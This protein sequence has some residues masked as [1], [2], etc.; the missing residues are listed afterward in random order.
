[1]DNDGNALVTGA[2]YYRTTV[3]IGMKVWDGAQWL[4][5]SAAQQ[6]SLVTYEYVATAGQTTFSGADANGVT[7]SYTVGNALVSVNGVRLRPGD[8][9]TATNGTSVVLVAAA[10]A[11]DEVLIDAFRTFEV[12]NTYT[13]AQVNALL[14][15]KLDTTG[16]TINGTLQVNGSNGP[17]RVGGSGYVVNP[18]NLVLGQYTS[19][20]TY[21]QFPPGGQ[22]EIW[23]GSTAEVATF[24]ENGN[25]KINGN[26]GI[27][28][29]TPTTSGAGI[30]FPATQSASSDANT[31][32]DYEEGTWTPTLNGCGSPTYAE[33]YGRYIKIGRQVSIVL[34]LAVTGATLAGNAINVSG[35][36]FEVNDASDAGQRAFA[37]IGGDWQNMG[38][39]VS[40]GVLRTNSTSLDGVRDNGSGSSVYWYYSELGSTSFEF[41]FIL[42]YLATA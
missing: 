31:L 6:A 27:G 29:V 42:T 26:I 30:T 24:F 9:F 33:R 18:P 25:A 3:P 22:L 12:A 28:N 2:L 39:Y 35:L 34:K 14:A 16:G 1:M 38:S 23:K 15:Q 36:P 4:E 20:R 19:T 11:G 40:N 41:S 10:A 7:L 37:R 13:Q 21:V 17:L 8:D 32:D 5:A